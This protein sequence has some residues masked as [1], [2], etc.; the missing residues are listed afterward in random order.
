MD[1]VLPLGAYGS[2]KLVSFWGKSAPAYTKYLKVA[3]KTGETVYLSELKSQ[4]TAAV[5]YTHLDVYKRQYRS[6]SSGCLMRLLLTTLLRICCWRAT[7]TI[8]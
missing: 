2:Q 1:E 7:S 6:R 8:F 4:G 3:F 5:S